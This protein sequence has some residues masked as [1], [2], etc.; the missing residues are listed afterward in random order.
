MPIVVA[1][2]RLARTSL[3]PEDIIVNTFHFF[4]DAPPTQADALSIADKVI[5]FYN[6]APTGQTP[7]ANIINPMV[8]RGANLCEVKLYDLGQLKPRP[9]LFNK[10]FTLGPVASGGSQYPAEVAIVL[11]LQTT[12]P[13]GAP[14]ARHRGRLYIGPVGSNTDGGLVAGDVVIANGTRQLLL[15]AAGRLMAAPADLIQ[16]G[17][18]SRVDGEIRR[19]I[20]SSVDDRYDT[21]RRRGAKPTSRLVGN[22]GGG[23]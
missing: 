22:A 5:A 8:S 17:I 18:Y 23:I 14:P 3:L 6:T 4:V 7:V 2:A 19:V 11:S 12:R 21:Q 16:W 15:G 13:A 20:G 9:V 10:F 1:Q